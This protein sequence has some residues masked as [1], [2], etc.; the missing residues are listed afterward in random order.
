MWGCEVMKQNLY[1]LE[2]KIDLI[3]LMKKKK[4]QVRL[5]FKAQ[6]NNSGYKDLEIQSFK[7]C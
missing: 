3:D 7:G 6:A 5:A 1:V 2:G 4:K